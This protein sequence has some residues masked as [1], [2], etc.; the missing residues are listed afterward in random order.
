M[1]P[2]WARKSELT[3]IASTLDEQAENLEQICAPYQSE[4]AGN[5]AYNYATRRQF[6]PG[7]GY[8]EAQ[9]LHG[10]IRRL[11]PS[12]IIEVGSGVSTSCMVEA[13]KLNK[14]QTDRTTRFT[15]IEPYPSEA[16]VQAIPVST[17]EGLRAG[18]LLFIDSSHAVRPGNDMNYLITGDAAAAWARRY[19]SLPRHLSTNRWKRRCCALT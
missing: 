16:Q 7:H 6:G 17:F 4:Y 1:K 19:G 11:L 14:R 12:R 9:T 3:G 8:I 2:V 13:L 15:C 5:S 18:D 10:V